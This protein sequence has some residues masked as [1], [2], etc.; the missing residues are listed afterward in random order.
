MKYLLSQLQKFL[1]FTENVSSSGEQWACRQWYCDS[2]DHVS[3]TKVDGNVLELHKV[4]KSEA[5]S[6]LCIASN[7]HPPTVS[8][9]VQIDIKCKKKWNTNFVC[10][11]ILFQF[12]LLYMFQCRRSWRTPGGRF[13]WSATLSPTPEQRWP[14]TSL[15][16]EELHQHLSTLTSS[17]SMIRN[18][19]NQSV[20]SW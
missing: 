15:G 13:S 5:G 10:K 3:V 14:G 4:K 17:E 16:T 6:Y 2:H 12:G 8:R 11:A 20:I 19:Y 1:V 18:V 7:G 9:R